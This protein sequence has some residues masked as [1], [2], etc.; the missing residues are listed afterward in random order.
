MVRHSA[1][2]DRLVR[3]YV[4]KAQIRFAG[5][6]RLKIFGML[7]CAQ[8]KRMKKENRVFFRSMEDAIN[9]GYRPCGHCMKAAYQQWKDGFVQ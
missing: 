9:A 3:M 1:I 6:S 2:D 5:N 4:R 7:R 8:G